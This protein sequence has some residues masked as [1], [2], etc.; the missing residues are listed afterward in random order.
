MNN[1]SRN[2]SIFNVKT[3]SQAVLYVN[4][5]WNNSSHVTCVGRHGKIVYFFIIFHV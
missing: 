5:L 3:F 4:H 2:L 1:S